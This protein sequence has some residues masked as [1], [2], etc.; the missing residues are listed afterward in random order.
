[1]S[2]PGIAFVMVFTGNVVL[3][4]LFGIED[5]HDRKPASGWEA[6]AI[7]FLGAFAGLASATA[8]WLLSLARASF[9][10]A[11]AIL[12]LVFLASR[13]I[14]E[15]AKRA[16]PGSAPRIAETMARIEASSIAYAIGLV[17]AGSGVGW[18]EGP[19]AGLAAAAGYFAATFLLRKLAARASLEDVPQPFRGK[20][21]LLVNAALVALAFTALDSIASRLTGK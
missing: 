15:A 9:A 19:V 16:R 1:M 10:L 14:E 21:L 5:A 4:A 6:A 11:P 2:A 3:D 12:I 18:I 13:G 17:V 20:P 8:S 7:A